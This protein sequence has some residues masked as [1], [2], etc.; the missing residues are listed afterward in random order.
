MHNRLLY[1]CILYNVSYSLLYIGELLYHEWLVWGWHTT[2][3]AIIDETKHLLD[4]DTSI[5][6][7]PLTV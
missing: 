1:I 3:N 5:S 7:V 6:S 4:T 2:N